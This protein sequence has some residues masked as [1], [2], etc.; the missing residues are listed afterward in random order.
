MPY[1]FLFGADRRTLSRVEG[2]VREMFQH[3]RREFE[4]ATAAL[5]GDMPADVVGR[6]IRELDRK[7]NA[8]EREIRRALV[9]HAS[10]QAHVDTPSL[11]IYMSIVKDVERLG[12]YAKNLVDLARDGARFDTLDDAAEWRQL[13][14]SLLTLIDRVGE[15][16]LS[17]G[18]EEAR[19]LLAPANQLLQRF[20]VHVSALVRGDDAGPQPVARALAYRYLKRVVAHLLNVLSA[21]IMPIDKLDFFD[22]D[23]DGRTPR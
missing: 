13:L 7:V 18:D 12:D 17:H 14:A 5:L 8:L 21:V 10:V 22:E 3:D 23:P 15:A 9:V 19:V 1:Q 20:N 4:L 16:F 2:L 6:D 11:L